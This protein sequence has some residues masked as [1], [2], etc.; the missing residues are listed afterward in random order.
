MRYN[1]RV[2]VLNGKVL[3]IRPKQYLASDGNYREER[4]FSPW[5]HKRV[6]D[7]FLLPEIIRKIT[8]TI[9]LVLMPRA[10]QISD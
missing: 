9:R 8:G 4:W 7:D 10:R 6:V 1:C 3:M 2:F 5:K